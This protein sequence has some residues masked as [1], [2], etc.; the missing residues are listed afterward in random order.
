VGT[1][2]RVPLPTDK[3][4]HLSHP[5]PNQQPDGHTMYATPT[6]HVSSSS[7]QPHARN[8]DQTYSQSKMLATQ[9]SVGQSGP[10]AGLPRHPSQ[11]S[12]AQNG[13]SNNATDLRQVP[14]CEE[15]FYLNLAFLYCIYLHYSTTNRLQLNVYCNLKK[16]V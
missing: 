11:P 7:M 1:L 5:V 2:S 10:R 15:L 13:Q 9:M 14:F 8:T 4:F 3:V 12:Y 6:A 16:T